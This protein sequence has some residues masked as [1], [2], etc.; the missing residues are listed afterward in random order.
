MLIRLTQ[1]VGA[2]FTIYTYVKLCTLKV[3]IL[4]VNLLLEGHYQ[5]AEK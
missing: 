3:T 2:P 5:L 4:F 1:V